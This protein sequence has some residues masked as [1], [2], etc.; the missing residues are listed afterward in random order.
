[1][2]HM[3]FATAASKCNFQQIPVQCLATVT[4]S[5]TMCDKQYISNPISNTGV[6]CVKSPHT[7]AASSGVIDHKYLF[8]RIYRPNSI[9]VVKCRHQEGIRG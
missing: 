6:F 5:W 4:P 9:L 7:P 2:I 1:M 3:H 8:C